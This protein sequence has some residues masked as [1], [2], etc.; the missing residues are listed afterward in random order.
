[1]K[2]VIFDI[3]NCLSNDGWRQDKLKLHQVGLKESLSPWHIYHDLAAFDKPGF[4]HEFDVFMRT[5]Q[6]DRV[7][8]LTMRPEI[9]R[10]STAHWLNIHFPLLT[11]KGELIM[12]HVD[13]IRRPVEVKR[14]MLS[15]VC[16]EYDTCIP[17]I[18]AAFDDNREILQM[19]RDEG[20][21]TYEAN[22]SDG[23]FEWEQSAVDKKQ[24]VCYNL[25]LS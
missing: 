1:M 25:S 16:M 13:D 3:D 20:V 23:V 5:V 14:S 19:Y 9:Y 10:Y 24:E 15:E 4:Q 17:N 12:R 11:E 6:P 7:F 21:I 2:E 18:V 22:I 8:F